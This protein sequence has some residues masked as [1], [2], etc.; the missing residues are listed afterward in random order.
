MSHDC[1]CSCNSQE[2]R[3]Y[4]CPSC[5]C[6]VGLIEGGHVPSCCGQSMQELVPNS[7][8]AS[9]EKHT[10]VVSVVGNSV[11]V[12]VPHPMDE[13]H[14]IPWVYLQTKRGGQ[15]KILA[16]GSEAKVVFLLDQDEPVAAYAYCNKHGL[17]KTTL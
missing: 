3:F 8:D 6:V 16:P 14:S 9:K 5:H 7:A 2:A 15:R 12:E 1:C 10:P 4:T 13:E 17:W 11:M